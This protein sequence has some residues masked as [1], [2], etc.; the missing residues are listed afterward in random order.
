MRVAVYGGSFNPPHVAHA[1]VASWLLWTGRADAVWLLPVYRHAFEGLHGK[2]LAPFDLRV[3]WC[4]A[5]AS[6]VHERLRVCDVERDLPVPSYS[7]VTLRHLASQ[8][9]EHSFRLVVGA[10][11]LGQLPKW[12]DWSAIASDFDPIIVGRAGYPPVPDAVSF[13][14]ISSTEIRHR[15][16]TGAPV[17]HLVTRGVARLL[18]AESFP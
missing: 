11:V 7:I 9:P 13:P 6:D 3:R 18:S 5:M 2:D 10:D 15:L 12:R 16:A 1:M 17:D 4:Q 8:H 14:D